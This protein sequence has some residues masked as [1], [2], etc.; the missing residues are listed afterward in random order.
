MSYPQR[1]DV[2]INSLLSVQVSLSYPQRG[3]V[4]EE[5]TEVVH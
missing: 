2:S 3:D 1:G 5:C 4:S